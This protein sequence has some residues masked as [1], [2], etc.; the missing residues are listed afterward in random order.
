MA[1]LDNPRWKDRFKNYRK[2][3]EQFEEFLELPE[4]N[5]YEE[6]GFVKAF[7]YTYE[8]GWKTLQDFLVDQGYLGIAGTK[9]VIEQ[10]YRDG[11]IDGEAWIRMHEARNTAAHVYDE[12]LFKEIVKKIRGDYQVTLKELR[13]LLSAYDR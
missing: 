11:Y 4:M 10:A 8:L 2:A 5:K 3:L 6:Q 12:Q 7:E 1:K 13:E 9:Q